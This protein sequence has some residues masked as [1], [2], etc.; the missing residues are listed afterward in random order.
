M[1]T[2]LDVDKV[3]RRDIPADDS[4][5]WYLSMN[6]SQREE[7]AKSLSRISQAICGRT[8]DDIIAH[9]DDRCVSREYLAERE[10]ALY[11]PTLK[12]AM[13]R[14]GHEISQELEEK[15]SAHWSEIQDVLTRQSA[16]IIEN[17]DKVKEETN[18]RKQD[19]ERIAAVEARL[20]V[21]EAKQNM[22]FTLAQSS[23][24]RIMSLQDQTTNVQSDI[25]EIKTILIK[26]AEKSSAKA[27]T[28]KQSI[29]S[30]VPLAAWVALAGALASAIIY[31]ITGEVVT[32]GGAK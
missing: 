32:F 10:D 12:D 13:H 27:A 29:L 23:D 2:A 19:R 5:H 4:G 8:K 22:V 30:K 6:E 24:T 25:S 26:S 18:R 3:I 16:L 9:I 15:L 31:L 1:L 28:P 14:V 11:M 7:A 17:G 20:E 21:W